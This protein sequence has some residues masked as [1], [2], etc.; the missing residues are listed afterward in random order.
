MKTKLN[1]MGPCNECRHGKTAFDD[2]MTPVDKD[3]VFI[4][5]IEGSVLGAMYG[6]CEA[7]HTEKYVNWWHENGNKLGPENRTQMECYEPTDLSKS[8]AEMSSIL[9]EMNDLLKKK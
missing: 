9:E 3:M 1:N 5:K 8:L 4:T 2:G 7:G 6:K